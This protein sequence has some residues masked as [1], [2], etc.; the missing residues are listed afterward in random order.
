MSKTINKV[1][2]MGNLGRDP[3]IRYTPKGA[4]V[5]NISLATSETWRDKESGK[6]QERTQWHKVSFFN[7]LAKIAGQR[8]RKGAKI[9]I[10]GSL[11]TRK[12]KDKDGIDHCVTQIISD[13]M[14]ILSSNT[15]ECSG[16]N[17][18]CVNKVKS[19]VVMEELVEEEPKEEVENV[20]KSDTS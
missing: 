16:F 14:Y 11:N 19:H 17:K 7:G 10:E 4:T 8:L 3:E 2:L 20:I 12:F 6:L 1:I 9:Y 15:E 13:D 5:V 18:S